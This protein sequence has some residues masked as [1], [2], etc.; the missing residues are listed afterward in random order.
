MDLYEVCMVS[1]SLTAL[2]LQ[3]YVFFMVQYKSPSCMQSYRYFLNS[4]VFWDMLFSFFFGIVLGPCPISIWI[5][6]GVRGLTYHFGYQFT[7]VMV[8][9]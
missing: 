4:L 7:F 8:S 6:V 1:I 9:L 5:L 3:L 2:F